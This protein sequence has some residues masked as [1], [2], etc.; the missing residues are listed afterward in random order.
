[1]S[2]KGDEEEKEE[3]TK[4]QMYL[5]ACSGNDECVLPDVLVYKFGLLE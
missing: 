2:E 4:K 5:V 1:V 3:I